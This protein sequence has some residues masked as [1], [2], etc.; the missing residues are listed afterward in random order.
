MRISVGDKEFSVEIADNEQARRQGLLGTASLKEGD[1]ML[2]KQDEAAIIPITMEGMKYPLALIFIYE[3]KV[4]DRIKAEV[5][6]EFI[7]STQVSDMVLEINPAD[8]NGIKRGNKVSFTGTKNEDGTVEMAHGGIPKD[9]IRQV[10]DEKG[11]NQMNLLGGERIFSRI[12]TKRMF[13]LAK[14][15]K[16]KTLGRYLYKEIKAQDTRPTQYSDN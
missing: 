11:R 2:L 6:E 3:N 4:V 9:G 16:Y 8:A 12:S 5:G 14:E 10:L 7:T 1:G 13:E 15:K